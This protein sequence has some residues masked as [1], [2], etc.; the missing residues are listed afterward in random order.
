MNW[1]SSN[2]RKWFSVGLWIHEYW[3][4]VAIYH[5]LMIHQNERQMKGKWWDSTSSDGLGWEGLLNDGVSRFIMH[6]WN[7]LETFPLNDLFEISFNPELCPILRSS[8]SFSKWN[9][10]DGSQ[11]RFKYLS[12]RGAQLCTNTFRRE[13]IVKHHL[14]VPFVICE[15][16]IEFLTQNSLVK[17]R[18][19]AFWPKFKSWLVV[20]LPILFQSLLSYRFLSLLTLICHNKAKNIYCT[21]SITSLT[22]VR[23]FWKFLKKSSLWLYLFIQIYKRSNIVK[24]YY[25]SK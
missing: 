2:Q 12:L 11:G 21:L 19:I 16:Y 13:T 14:S 20:F 1:N 7:C 6:I 17:V 5:F 3:L 22:S 15:G 8:A 24:K 18:A 9:W 23:F 10:Q 25:S 4:M